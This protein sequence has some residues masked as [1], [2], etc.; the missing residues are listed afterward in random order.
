VDG[1][2][3]KACHGALGVTPTFHV[4][5][6]ND[7]PSCSFCHTPNR[8]ISGWSSSSKVFIHALHGA[9]SRTTA[10]TWHAT[11]PGAWFDGGYPARLNDCAT[12]HLPG[13]YD[14]SATASQAAAPNLLVTTVAT[15]RYYA[16]QA[17]A[18][19]FAISPYV[20]ADNVADYGY[21]FSTANVTR[22]LPDGTSG[23]QGS[24]TCTPATPCVCTAANPCVVTSDAGQQGAVSCS[25]PALCTCTTANTCRVT[26]KTCTVMAPCGADATTLVISPIAAACVGCHDSTIA[27]GHYESSGG[28][29]YRPRADVLAPTA[30]KEQCLLCHA[31]GK[32]AGIE[33]MHR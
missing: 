14:L 19:W 26:V 1:A 30:P 20:Q 29:F 12:C 21:G 27:I 10:F 3:C 9:R 6:A 31:L 25:A 24:T 32:I 7:A 13:T 11:A 8:T 22:T 23:T 28:A 15:G 18:D 5:Q 2:R 16:N 33:A 4:G 17:T